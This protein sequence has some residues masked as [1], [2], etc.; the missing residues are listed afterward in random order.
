MNLVNPA[1]AI[2][3]ILLILAGLFFY[4]RKRF[5]EYHERTAFALELQDIVEKYFRTYDADVNRLA[6]F[7][8]VDDQPRAELDQNFE[9][10][11]A[12][13]KD[14]GATPLMKYDGAERAIYF[15]L[16]S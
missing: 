8:Y 11:K 1:F 14:R 15:I 5:L 9:A 3:V 10:L 7:F 12:D 13:L 16:S 2:P 4:L 6:I